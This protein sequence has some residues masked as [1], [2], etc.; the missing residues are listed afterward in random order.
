METFE[1]I[2]SSPLKHFC[3][4]FLFAL[5]LSYVLR[6]VFKKDHT[7]YV[8]FLSSV[9]LFSCFSKDLFTNLPFEAMDIP[10]IMCNLTG[11]VIGVLAESLWQKRHKN[12]KRRL[13]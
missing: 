3:T 4:Y 8:I 1:L 11:S 7:Y 6:F 12:S 2:L 9:L 5:I 13:A 10:K